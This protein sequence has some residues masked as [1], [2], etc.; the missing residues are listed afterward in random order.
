MKNLFVLLISVFALGQYSFAQA[1]EGSVEFDKKERP[2]VICEFE[3]TTDVIEEAV[4]ADLKEKGIKK[5]DNK[6]GFM[7]FEEVIFQQIS[8]NKIN[9]YVKIDEKKKDKT[10]LAFLV[11]YGL[12][13][14]ISSAMDAS[15]IKNTITYMNSLAPKFAATKLENDIEEQQKVYDKAKNEYENL[16]KDGE[17]LAQEKQKLEENIDKNKSEQKAKKEDMEKERLKLES[18]QGGKK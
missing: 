17:K 18:L 9:F 13:N 4:L 10:V 14:F 11:S 12:D 6:K 16:V 5:Y 1:K 7:I 2:A 8:V 3:Y 15:I